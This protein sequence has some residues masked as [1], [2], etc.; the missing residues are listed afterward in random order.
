MGRPKGETKVHELAIDKITCDAEIQPRRGEDP[1]L[2]RE[3]VEAWLDGAAFPPVD[4]FWDRDTDEYYL[5]D[6]FHRLKSAIAARRRSILAHLHLGTR[7]DAILCSVGANHSHGL[8]RSNDD[9]R[10]A[11]L[12]LLDDPEWC[13]WSDAEVARACNVSPS[14]VAQYRGSQTDV[15]GHA[16]GARVGADGKVAFRPSAG[17]ADAPPDRRT[18]M[19]SVPLTKGEVHRLYA[20]KLA[21]H[22]RR[23]D[24]ATR[25]DVPFEFGTVE[26]VT[27]R[28][29]YHTVIGR[30]TDSVYRHVG[31]MFVARHELGEAL[32]VTLVGH[33]APS[34]ARLIGVLAAMGVECVTP[35]TVL[36][37]RQEP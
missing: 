24:P 25:T 10:M 14:M 15:R 36:N 17:P 32:G 33:F 16:V 30:E 28:R 8:R 12:K 6:G 20:S 7:R 1:A 18:A 22:L 5:A 37:R 21:K 34:M 3:Y 31:R 27:S 19:G 35:E 23:A 2:M 4:V 26:I 29:L 9:K 13:L 11:V